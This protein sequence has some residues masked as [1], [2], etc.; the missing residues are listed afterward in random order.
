MRAR[1]SSARSVESRTRHRLCCLAP[2][3]V[4]QTTTP[5]IATTAATTVSATA[6]TVCSTQ[7]RM[8][9][10]MAKKHYPSHKDLD[11]FQ[12]NRFRGDIAD[13]FLRLRNDH[14]VM[15][16][17]M[18]LGALA[19]EFDVYELEVLNTAGF[20]SIRDQAVF[21]RALERGQTRQER[22]AQQEAEDR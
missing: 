14:Q 1:L 20:L 17:R 19:Y 16:E 11:P 5:I 8:A 18:W 15:E 21:R 9:A 22:G 7:R 10:Q 6:R 4:T 13:R 3:R 2:A 12:F